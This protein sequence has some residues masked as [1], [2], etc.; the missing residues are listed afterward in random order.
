MSLVNSFLLFAVN[1]LPE[2]SLVT[3]GENYTKQKLKQIAFE[4]ND[5][6]TSMQWY[7][8]QCFSS[9]RFFGILKSLWVSCMEYVTAC[10]SYWIFVRNCETLR[11]C[12]KQTFVI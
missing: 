11:L 10:E 4:D 1:I 3:D 5:A 6:L 7:R 12:Y 8:S 9:Q 2:S